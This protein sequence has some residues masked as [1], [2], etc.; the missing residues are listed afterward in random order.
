MEDALR[1]ANRQLNLMTSITRHDILNNIQAMLAYIEI[2]ESK[3]T[4]PETSSLLAKLNFATMVIQTQIEF[5]RIYQNLGAH[6]PQWQKLDRVIP[7]SQV[8]SHITLTREV[9]EVEVYADP[10]L[11]KVFYNLL[12]NT[13]RYGQNVTIIRVFYSDSPEGLTVIYEDNGVGIPTDE[14]K[15]IFE[16]GY[17]KNTGLGLFMAR[18]ILAITD[19]TIQETGVPGKGARFEINVP[20]GKYRITENSKGK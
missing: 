19:M 13:I 7:L 6:E 9:K 12:D 2:L 3:K 11:E 10:M 1:Q 16:R 20:K 18:E 8:S 17:G 15:R 4:D 14:K 5:T